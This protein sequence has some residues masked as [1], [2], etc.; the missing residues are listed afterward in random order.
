MP[1]PR[2]PSH[3][4]AVA[5][6]LAACMHVGRAH[7]QPGNPDGPPPGPGPALT[8]IPSTPPPPR[9]TSPFVYGFSLGLGYLGFDPG[10]TGCATCT[11]IPPALHTHGA[12]GVRVAPWLAVGGQLAA[13]VELVSDH[14]GSDARLG[15]FAGFVYGQLELIPTLQL[16][17]GLGYG[18]GQYQYTVQEDEI[19]FTISRDK[20]DSLGSGPAQLAAVRFVLPPLFGAFRRFDFALEARYTRIALRRAGTTHGVSLDFVAGKF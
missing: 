13:Q 6:T 5:A 15:V 1:P 19:L 14:P 18:G 7:A 10:R 2:H 16:I 11:A 8:P 3:R 17:G 4:L 20:T 12:F 9:P